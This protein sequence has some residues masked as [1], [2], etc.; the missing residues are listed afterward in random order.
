MHPKK[1]NQAHI[2]FVVSGQKNE[3]NAL[4]L[5]EITEPSTSFLVSQTS[6]SWFCFYLCRFS[7]CIW[8]L[9]FSVTEIL[10]FWKHI[11]PASTQ[12]QTQREIGE[13]SYFTKGVVSPWDLRVGI[14]VL[15]IPGEGFAVQGVAEAFAG[16][17][18]PVVH[19][20]YTCRQNPNANRCLP[21]N[22]WT[23]SLNASLKNMQWGQN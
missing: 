20:H 8:M 9:R 10:S 15:Q 13:S 18:V 16:G 19:P 4:V 22:I 23:D 2:S 14:N 11:S 7:F 3:Q 21:S 5:L 6:C 17:N 12:V 1:G